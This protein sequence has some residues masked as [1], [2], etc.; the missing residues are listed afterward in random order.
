MNK[1]QP[2]P[3][4]IREIEGNDLPEQSGVARFEVKERYRDWI[5]CDR[6]SFGEIFKAWDTYVERTVAL[7]VQRPDPRAHENQALFRHEIAMTAQLVHPGVVPIYDWGKLADGRIWFAMKWVEGCTIAERIRQLHERRGGDFSLNFRRLLDD[8][9]RLC[10][11]VAYA[12]G[13]NI[14]HR[15]LKPENLMIGEFGEVHV[16]DWALARRISRESQDAPPLDAHHNDG[17]PSANALRTRIAGTPHY[18]PPEQAA[19]NIE[20]M[21]PRS[22]VYALGAVLYE[23]LCGRPPYALP[24]GLSEH[25]LTILEKVRREAPVSIRSVARPEVPEAIFVICEKAM[26]RSP[27]ERHAHAG[28]LMQALRD[29]QDGADREAR[30]RKIILDARHELLPQIDEQWANVAKLRQ[31]ARVFLDRFHSFD[32]AQKKAEGWKMQDDA[33][34]LEQVVLR[35][36][37]H[38]L[39][40]IRSA[41]EEAPYLEEAHEALAEYH[42]KSLLRAEERRD[43][44]ATIAEQAQVENH[45]KHL[46]PEKR[47]HYSR[48]LEGQGSLSLVTIPESAHVIIKPYR[49]VNRSLVLGE[50]ITQQVETPL[51]NL[52]L[53][54]G[55]YLVHLSKPGY[56]DVAYPIFIGRNEHWDG[57]RPGEKNPFPI[58]L[59][60]EQD[61]EA[62][63]VY[64][65]AGFFLAGGDPRAGESLPRK[66]VWV[67][68]FVIRRF[69]VTNAEF[70]AFLNKL[71]EAGRA[72]EAFAH[73]PRLSAGTSANST[74][75]AY[76]RDENTGLF[77]LEDSQKEATLPVV[78]ID[79]FAATAYARHHAE[80]TGLPWRLPSELEWEKAARGVDG[81]YLPWGDQ[82]E[83]TWAC[84][85]G[86]HPDRKN[87]MPVDSYR[88][89]V[90]PYGV[91]GMAGNVKDWCLDSWHIDGPRTDDGILL[92]NSP[93]EGCTDERLIRG[94]AWI[95]VPE[96]MRV[97]IRYAG[98]PTQRHGTL[99]FR[100]ARSF[101]GSS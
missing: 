42:T 83:P 58:E 26:Q 97:A 66:R 55:S 32:K 75:I 71:V 27:D 49:L 78:Q 62:D 29:W 7:K 28:E 59:P 69:P 33:N 92:M 80:Q 56:R 54:S 88:T 8:F 100:L 68:A 21:G 57:V 20:K 52:P 81:R 47:Q 72:A 18:M 35:K 3:P 5:P 99:G 85:A 51:Q 14:I 31:E 82:L 9:R 13:Q 91:R 98:P 11:P 53:P 86:S 64:V 89:D 17:D 76:L 22:D 44:A 41:L 6:G 67:D 45:L 25:H 60:Q 40:K 24:N 79:W 73:C 2:L 15:D 4:T 84:V 61:L 94:G 77:A 46:P 63:D 95:S 38:Y 39:Q 19:G 12:H 96:T 36:E 74:D 16:M 101:I 23:I 48:I 10:E 34:L 1:D 37:I 93:R 65:P 50:P 90:S 87:V 43:V 70:V 30:G